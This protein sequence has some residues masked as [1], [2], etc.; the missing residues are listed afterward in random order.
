MAA[1][2]LYLVIAAILAVP[3]SWLL[4]ARIAPDGVALW[5]LATLAFLSPLTAAWL[6]LSAAGTIGILSLSRHARFRGGIIILWAELLLIG[7]F[8]P[9][10]MPVINMVGAAYFTLRNLHV[11]LDGYLQRD[12]PADFRGMFRYQFF[13]P[14]LIAGPIHRYPN[15]TRNLSRRRFDGQDLAIGA[16][17]ALVGLTIASLLGIHMMG[18]VLVSYSVATL[19]WPPFL[20][21]WG[22]STLEWVQLYFIFGG[23]SSV[24]VG[25]SRMMGVVIEENFDHPYRAKSLLDFWTRWHI[26]LSLWCRD[27]VFQTVTAATRQPIIGLLAAMAAIGIWHQTS[28]FYLLWALWQVI[29]IVLNRLLIAWAGRHNLRL[30]R[31]VA[32]V[33]APIAILGWLSLARPTINYILGIAP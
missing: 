23:L 18:K 30:P 16:E 3:I 22:K 26:S 24:A 4:P 2:A 10:E 15:F 14:V 13:A 11:L 21:G 32:V 17:R 20:Y 25:L 7:L 6:A 28:V 9:R 27:Y 29:G 1:D 31:L 8:V 33:V 19:L 12:T 5:T